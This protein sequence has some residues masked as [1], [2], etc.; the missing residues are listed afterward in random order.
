[1]TKDYGHWCKR[2]GIFDAE[3]NLRI[4]CV[5]VPVSG[6]GSA[7]REKNFCPNKEYKNHENNHPLGSRK[8]T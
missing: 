6:S 3:M 8:G 2:F 4:T 7:N 5:T 1:M